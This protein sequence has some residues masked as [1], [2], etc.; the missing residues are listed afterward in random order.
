M[1]ELFYSKM[2]YEC[3][4]AALS[5]LEIYCNDK[6]AIKYLFLCEHNINN[7]SETIG[8]ES[9]SDNNT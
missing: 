4:K 3:R 1:I 8:I 2:W 7:P 6:T 9:I 5:Y